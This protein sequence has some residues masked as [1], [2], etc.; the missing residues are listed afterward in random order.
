MRFVD[1]QKHEVEVA[2][3]ESQ[4]TGRL[5]NFD[6]PFD[7]F[8]QSSDQLVEEIVANLDFSWSW[9]RNPIELNNFIF[10]E[11]CKTDIIRTMRAREPAVQIRRYSAFYVLIFLTWGAVSPY[12]PVFLAAHGWHQALVGALLLAQRSVAMVAAPAVGTI[13]RVAGGKREK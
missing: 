6:D 8:F 3:E 5:W 11:F 2:K 4:S 10:F 1:V 12:W 7:P 9:I 13:E